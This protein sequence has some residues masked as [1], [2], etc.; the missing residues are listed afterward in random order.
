M[1]DRYRIII[2]VDADDCKE[3]T[4]KL[5]DFVKRAEAAGV[6]GVTVLGYGLGE[7]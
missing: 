1:K 6:Q 2:G 3:S 5:L 4:R 7:G